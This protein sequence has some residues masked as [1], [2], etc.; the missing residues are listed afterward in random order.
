MTQPE[1]SVDAFLGGLVTV[2]QTREGHRAGL[3]AALLQA[4]VPT[5]AAG[6]A[7]DLGTGVG[8]VAFCIAARAA[9]LDVVGLDCDPEALACAR[10]ALG[11][12]ANA[13]FAARVRFV[14]G[15][16]SADGLSMPAELRMRPADWLLMN[17]PFDVQDR[18]RGSPDP[19]R[20]AAHVAEA[21]SLAAWCG[22]AAALLRPGGYLGIVHRAAAVPDLLAAL[23][24]RFGDIR[25]VPV[26]PSPER[27]ARRV[28]LRARRASRSPFVLAPALVLHRPDGT[29]TPEAEQILRG[30]GVL[31]L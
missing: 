7:V 27:P 11:H 3:D 29:W 17:P 21:G 1:R 19:R 22:Q 25:I 31:R 26:H 6:F 8:T 2:I 24:G 4:L 10:A 5:D 15:Q 13:A 18:T 14:L 30:K 28:L 12:P 20:R 16:V 9:E 23:T